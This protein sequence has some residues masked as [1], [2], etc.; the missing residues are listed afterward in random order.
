[1]GLTR[2]VGPGEGAGP[3]VS[4]APESLWPARLAILGVL[5]LNLLLG[6]HLTPGPNWL[7]PALEVLLLLP[8]S[9]LR[10]RQREH[11]RRYGHLHPRLTQLTRPLSLALTGLLHLANL[12]S[13]GLL[14]R[15]LLQGS[16][17]TGAALLADALNLWVTNVLVFSLWYWELDRG[18]ALSRSLPGAFP[19]F[20]FPQ[21]G[22]PGLAPQ[23]WRPE[24]VDYL[25]VACTNAAAFSPTDTLPL[26]RRAKGLMAF[27]ALTSLLTLV[28]VASRAVNILR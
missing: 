18:G 19:D 10:V 27:Q 9:A 21:Q 2:P 16:G 13:L 23:E 25:F 11:L 26:T 1:M 22:T 8:L 3:G 20:L 15:G 17:A 24:Y 5:A 28:L 7:L 6:E 12:T 14:V 4:A